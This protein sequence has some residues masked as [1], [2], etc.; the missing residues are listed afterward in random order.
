MDM[1]DDVVND[2]WALGSIV[3]REGSAFADSATGDFF[4]S[5]DVID[6]ADAACCRSHG[7]SPLTRFVSGP[8]VTP[9]FFFVPLGGGYGTWMGLKI[10]L[11]VNAAWGFHPIM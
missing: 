2:A 8:W 10:V 11:A 9:N 5:S 7:K 4:G 1:T 6:L 3:S